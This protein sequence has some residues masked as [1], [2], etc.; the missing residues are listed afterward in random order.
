MLSVMAGVGERGTGLGKGDGSEGSHPSPNEEASLGDPD[1]RQKGLAAAVDGD[2]RWHGSI[3]GGRR[4]FSRARGTVQA[5]IAES[6]VTHTRCLRSASSPW[7]SLAGTLCCPTKICHQ[8]VLLL[9]LSA[10]TSE[11]GDLPAS[12]LRDTSSATVE[13]PAPNS[14]WDT[15]HWARNYSIRRVRSYKTSQC[16]SLSTE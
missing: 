13:F 7:P 5:L 15:S 8:G 12:K 14:L 10:S 2:A 4:H 1:P 6:V 11:H 16:Y 9:S 3:Q